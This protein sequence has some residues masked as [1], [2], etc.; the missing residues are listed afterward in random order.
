MIVGI[1]NTIN[2]HDMKNLYTLLFIPF[3]LLCLNTKTAAV[4]YLYNDVTI[5]TDTLPPD[6][7]T[8]KNRIDTFGGIKGVND[9]LLKARKDSMFK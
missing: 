5:K 2:A 8:A 6:T 4:K 9:T 1:N 3:S 7:S